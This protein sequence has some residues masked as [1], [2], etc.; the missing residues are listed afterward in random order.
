M[1][2]LLSYYF[3]LRLISGLWRDNLQTCRYSAPHQNFPGFC[4]QGLIN[5]LEVWHGLR[6]ATSSRSYLKVTTD[7]KQCPQVS[8]DTMIR[9]I[10]VFKQEN[11]TKLTQLKEGE[12]RG[13]GERE[14]R[15]E[16]AEDLERVSIYLP[17]L[18]DLRSRT[19]IR[20]PSHPSCILPS[21]HGS[22]RGAQR[23]DVGDMRHT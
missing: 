17:N 18:G 12:W 10:R 23:G 1:S 8:K 20:T 5:L 22:P 2:L 9:L 3:P 14:G 7:V 6:L 11:E 4:I 19:L 13:V 16:Y 21:L 15:D